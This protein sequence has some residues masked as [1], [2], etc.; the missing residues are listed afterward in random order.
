MGSQ[1]AD[2]QSQA[3]GL[4]PMVP[5]NLSHAGHQM[6]IDD[7]QRDHDEHVHQPLDQGGL[8]GVSVGGSGSQ[9]PWRNFEEAR[10]FV[11]SFK[12]RDQKAWRVWSKSGARPHDIPSHPDS[13]YAETGWLS[14]RDWLGTSQG[15]PPRATKQKWKSFDEARDFVRSLH[16]DNQKEWRRWSSLHRPSDIPSHPH[17]AYKAVGWL[18]WRDWLGTAEGSSPRK[19]RV[20]ARKVK[21]EV[22]PEEPEACLEDENCEETEDEAETEERPPTFVEVAIAASFTNVRWPDRSGPGG[23]DPLPY[24][25]SQVHLVMPPLGAQDRLQEEEAQCW[26][27]M[28][29]KSDMDPAQEPEPDVEH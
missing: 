12:M 4:G 25:Q 29:K 18:S 23:A 7:R 9:V 17:T 19:S 5:Q 8:I 24:H 20:L 14:W 1:D 22:P 3:L 11:R 15:R 16:L 2:L 26:M 13:A 27:E 28:G 21:H 10:T 6:D